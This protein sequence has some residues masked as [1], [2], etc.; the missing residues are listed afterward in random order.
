MVLLFMACLFDKNIHTDTGN[1][2]VDTQS[3]SVVAPESAHVINVRVEVTLDGILTEGVIVRQPGVEREWI[4]NS[5]GYADIEVDTSLGGALAISASH[6]EAQIRGEEIYRFAD[7][8]NV[9]SIELIRYNTEDHEDYI[10]QDPGTPEN[11]QS[12][13][14]LW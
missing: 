7:F 4:S 10:F 12:K 2:V 14:H 6:P 3:D 9:V 13:A 11:F 1:S 5:D 8:P